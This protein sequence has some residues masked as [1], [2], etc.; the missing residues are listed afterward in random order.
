MNNIRKPLHT[1]QAADF[2]NE[3]TS[4]YDCRP[5]FQNIALLAS[6]FA[7]RRKK[8]KD[9]WQR[10]EDNKFFNLQ[11]PLASRPR[12]S[13]SADRHK[14]TSAEVTSETSHFANFIHL[15]HCFPQFS[16]QVLSAEH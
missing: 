6:H 9:E 3:I 10:E 13:L 16:G 2:G 5:G 4:R 8:K 11:F 1:S 7:Q 12:N 14:A 15:R